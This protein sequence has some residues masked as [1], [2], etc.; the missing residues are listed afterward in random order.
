MVASDGPVKDQNLY[1]ATVPNSS[2]G[3][4]LTIGTTYYW[5][6]DTIDVDH[7][8]T[9]TGDVWSFTAGAIPK[10]V[11]PYY[12][13]IYT[14]SLNIDEAILE[15]NSDVAVDHS[16][17]IVTPEGGSPID[18]G[19]QTSPFDLWAYNVANP[20]I[21]T[22]KWDTVYSWQVVEEDADN[23]VIGESD[24]WKFA[25]RALNCTIT[26]DLTGDCVVNLEDF[27]VMASGWLDCGWDDG[28]YNSPCP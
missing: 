24:V 17:V 26:T 20:G 28:G 12:S 18:C 5:R 23:N 13:P 19:I 14:S 9:I 2:I 21:I 1:I 22:L 10:M 8:D 15:W 27:A 6:V 11:A 4:P 3:G 16:R 7:S 25:I